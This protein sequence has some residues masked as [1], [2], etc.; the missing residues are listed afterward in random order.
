MCV[1]FGR[2]A[3]DWR[4]VE[5]SPSTLCPGRH[6]TAHTGVR[7]QLPLVLVGVHN[8]AKIHAGNRRISACIMDFTPKIVGFRPDVSCSD[9][10]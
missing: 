5:Q 9:R 1:L 3:S 2:R 6:D 7:D 8:D 4:G 10:V